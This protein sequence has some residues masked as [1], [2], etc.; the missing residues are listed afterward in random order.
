MGDRSY[1]SLFSLEN[2]I[3]IPVEE[4]FE[5]FWYTKKDVQMAK[6]NMKIKRLCT[7]LK[8]DRFKIVQYFVKNLQ[9]LDDKID[10]SWVDDYSHEDIVAKSALLGKKHGEIPLCLVNNIPAEVH[11]KSKNMVKEVGEK[12]NL[13]T[14]TAVATSVSG[15]VE[16]DFSKAGL[17]K[18]LKLQRYSKYFYVFGKFD[19]PED[20]REEMKLLK[21]ANDPVRKKKVE[22]LE[23]VMN[24]ADEIHQKH[25]KFEHEA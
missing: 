12:L 25:K 15:D 9:P 7:Q 21:K 6:S 2:P 14:I 10:I 5:A 8:S 3:E 13:T 11:A 4:S 18:A 23:K 1:E 20:T 22:V 19:I 17:K 16:S 24:K